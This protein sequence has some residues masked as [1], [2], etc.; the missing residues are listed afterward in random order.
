[1]EKWFVTAKRADF[2]Q[3]SGKF[4]INPVTARIIRN[5][6]IIGDEAIQ[7]YLNGG[8]KDLHDPKL[9]YGAREAVA[10]LNSKINEGRKIRIIGDYDIDGVNATYILY[11][12]L[13]RC[14]ANVDYEI[15][16]RMKDGYGINE[17]LIQYA[18]EEGVDTI[19]TCDNGIAAID[20]IAYAKKL[21][22]TVIITDHHELLFKEEAGEKI[23][24]RPQADV[25]INPKQPECNYPFPNLCGAAVAFKLISCLFEDHQ[26]PREE[27]EAF[28]EFAAIATVGDVMDLIG[29]NRIIVKEGLR[30]LTNTQ[31]NGLRSL[32]KVNG[33]DESDICA[34]HIGFV[35]GPCINA[36]G[37]LDTAKRA[38]ALLLAETDGEAL[39]MAE[40]LKSLND[41]RKSMTLEGFEKAVELVETTELKNDKVLVVYLPDCHESLAGIIAGRIRERFHK[42]VFVLTDAEDGVKGS[43]RSI[44]AYNMF[45]EMVKC[46]EL[47]T[48]FG[49]HPMAAGLSIKK[50]DVENLRTRL[51]EL[52]TLTEEDFIPRVS[53][54]VA[55]PIDYISEELIG[56]LEVLEPFGKANPKPVFAEKN[57]NVLSA[58]ILGQNKNVI[59]MQVLNSQGMVMDAMYFGDVEKFNTYITEKF[60]MSEV[61]K[62]YQNRENAVTISAT[63]YPQVNVFR[64]VRN[65]QI[66]IQNYM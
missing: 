16:D 40:E 39:Q 64:N 43:G 44:E 14:N 3:I 62:V 2:Q 1:M 15:P 55:M 32:I 28:I 20:Q 61:E 7:E 51:N 57:L 12:G 63:Y 10:L 5:R 42:P 45:E 59:K 25:I 66:V 46:Q 9:L 56:E 13:K 18:Y 4:G 23:C 38:L 58:R 65:M 30:R 54:D 29:E 11:K 50:E 52:T 47:F 31:N 33:L 24:L 8:M 48:K 19:V 53:I 21:G 22:M 6:D 35:L 36:S 49:G 37:R 27:A 26:I 60:G 34:Y 17:Q 41:E